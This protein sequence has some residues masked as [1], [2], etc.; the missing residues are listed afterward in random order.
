MGNQRYWLVLAIPLAVIGAACSGADPAADAAQMPG[1]DDADPAEPTPS[2]EP[3]PQALSV[4]TFVLEP[5][6]HGI[7]FGNVRF[8][9]GGA[10]LSDEDPASRSA[11]MGLLSSAWHL[12]LE[13]SVEN[14]N[15]AATLRVDDRSFI[16]LRTV[17]GDIAAKLS[18]NDI[19]PRS[20]IQPGRT[21]TYQVSY[22]VPATFELADAQLVFGDPGTEQIVLDLA[23]LQAPPLA[24]PEPIPLSLDATVGGRVVCGATQLASSVTRATQSLDLPADVA[25]TG[26]L[27]LRAL[28]GHRFLE[29]DVAFT[30]SEAPEPGGVGSGCVGT[31]V[32]DELVSLEVDGVPADKRYIEGEGSGEAQLGETVTLTIGFMVPTDTPL[33]LILGSPDGTTATAGFSIG[34]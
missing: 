24:R 25:A 29:I 27:P 19:S 5:T 11:G 10:E 33:N 26:G 7:T 1:V 3:T 18:S 34:T 28:L 32:S 23:A 6:P 13:I 9:I 30:V 21:G 8:G 4:T 20:M 22:E 2:P 15:Q 17:A 31:I 14:P 16:F 12:Y